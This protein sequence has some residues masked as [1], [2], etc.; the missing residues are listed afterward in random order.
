MIHK[1]AACECADHVRGTAH[2]HNLRKYGAEV[3]VTV[4]RSNDLYR[5]M[6]VIGIISRKKREIIIRAAE[7][8]VSRITRIT[9][10]VYAHL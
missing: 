8:R 1:I 5:V 7:L 9:G 4:A 3:A 2:A 6:I 10:Q